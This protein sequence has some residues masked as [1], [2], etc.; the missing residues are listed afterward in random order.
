MKPN[1]SKQRCRRPWGDES[2][3]KGYHPFAPATFYKDIYL[4]R[5]LK[6]SNNQPRRRVG[7]LLPQQEVDLRKP[8]RK[9][10]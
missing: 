3:M 10:L 5:Y 8:F 9:R 2:P 1:L 4:A 7:A 6:V